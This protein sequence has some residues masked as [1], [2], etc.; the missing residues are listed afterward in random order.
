MIIPKTATTPEKVDDLGHPKRAKTFRN[1]VTGEVTKI[2]Q[3]NVEGGTF[4][5]VFACM[6]GAGFALASAHS[7]RIRTK[8]FTKANH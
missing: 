6:C 4:V 7:W 5:W 2:L 1:G 8:W 3:Q